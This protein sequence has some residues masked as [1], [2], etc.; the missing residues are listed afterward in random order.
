MSRPCSSSRLSDPI[1]ARSAFRGTA[2]PSAHK[3][4]HIESPGF[5]AHALQRAGSRTTQSSILNSGR[6]LYSRPF[7]PSSRRANKLRR[8]KQVSRPLCTRKP[9]TC[10]DGYD[11]VGSRCVPGVPHR[12]VAVKGRGCQGTVVVVGCPGGA[13]A[14]WSGRNGP[15]RG[16]AE[17]RDRCSGASRLERQE[18]LRVS[19]SRA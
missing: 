12:S 11:Q 19:S 14:R 4:L 16:E 13:R 3:H 2:S 9:D 5:A 17:G 10:C 1:Y 8:K 18:E 6:N 15:T 7:L